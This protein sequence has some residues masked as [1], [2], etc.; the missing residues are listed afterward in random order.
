MEQN[1][2][3]RKIEGALNSDEK[4][5]RNIVLLGI[6]SKIKN[7]IIE[8]CKK[9]KDKCIEID[10][11]D[12]CNDD[13]ETKIIEQLNNN[14]F[15]H[16]KKLD[17]L[18]GCKISA[19]IKTVFGDLEVENKDNESYGNLT[20]LLKFF[21]ETEYNTV[22][23]DIIDI[24]YKENAVSNLRS[25]AAINRQINNNEIIKEKKGKITFVY[26]IT[27]NISE[28]ITANMHENLFFVFDYT[29]EINV[30]VLDLLFAM[31]DKDIECSNKFEQ[32]LKKILDRSK[33]SIDFIQKYLYI[34]ENN[35]LLIPKL[36]E[37]SETIWED[38]FFCE[39]LQGETDKLDECLAK[40]L[41]YGKIEGIVRND[42]VVFIKSDGDN[43]KC[44]VNGKTYDI[45][46]LRNFC[47]LYDDYQLE[48]IEFELEHEGIEEC[49][50][51]YDYFEEHDTEVLGK[52]LD[53]K[54]DEKPVYK[55]INEDINDFLE[56]L[57]CERKIYINSDR[58]EDDGYKLDKW[59]WVYECFHKNYSE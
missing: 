41:V 50:L 58:Y 47:E 55:Y 54:L 33:E 25:L 5:C 45:E 20:K 51:M 52:M 10:I 46:A 53:E 7:K 30:E 1:E 8:L 3:I 57:N 36:L 18:N 44:K 29:K 11:T 27:E 32:F 59:N 26:N 17:M 23:I 15:G 16:K 48:D 40:I 34:G 49:Y 22:I 38:I 13:I 21:L 31:K 14:K 6:Q 24:M 39:S 2:I 9:E 42:N 19:N 35:D 28:N 43:K 56:G 12:L 4:K 37:K